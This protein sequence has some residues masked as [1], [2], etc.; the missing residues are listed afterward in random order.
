MN[1]NSYT[2]YTY[3]IEDGA[4]NST[5]ALLLLGNGNK[6]EF[7]GYTTNFNSDLIGLMN[8]CTYLSLN[9]EVL[10]VFYH[11]TEGYYNLILNSRVDF[12]TFFNGSDSDLHLDMGDFL[13]THDNDY[14]PLEDGGNQLTNYL[15]YPNG[16]NSTNYSETQVNAFSVNLP[17]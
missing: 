12:V 5:N 9:Y 2:K 15:F 13:N 14:Y 3:S 4:P 10:G 17:S 8:A 6:L 16:E 11:N 7:D 1:Y